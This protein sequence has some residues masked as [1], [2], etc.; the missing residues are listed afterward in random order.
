MPNRRPA[1]KLG[2]IVIPLAV[3][4]LVLAIWPMDGAMFFAI[5]A[6]ICFAAPTAGFW[7]G[8]MKGESGAGRAAIGCVGTVVLFGV[9][10]L[11]ALVVARFIFG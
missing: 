6:S 7:W 2:W 1:A 4:P 10:L 5:A 11:W 3:M 9:Y 8:E